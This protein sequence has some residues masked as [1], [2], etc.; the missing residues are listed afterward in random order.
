MA[1]MLLLAAPAICT[2][3]IPPSSSSTSTST[4]HSLSVSGC[5]TL[6]R[7]TYHLQPSLLRGLCL[8]QCQQLP[9]LLQV[10]RTAVYRERSLHLQ[11]T[12]R[13][14]QPE[15]TMIGGI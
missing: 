8:V 12:E 7:F 1:R 3:D 15:C 13:T 10:E 11:G 14:R 9:Q 4:S 5:R 6:E 2:R